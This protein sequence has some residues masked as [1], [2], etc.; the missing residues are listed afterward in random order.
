M[1]LPT[2]LC[3]CRQCRA[4]I[5]F[6]SYDVNAALAGIDEPEETSVWH[7]CGNGG[8]QIQCI[9]VYDSPSFVTFI[10]YQKSSLRGWLIAVTHPVEMII[11]YKG[12]Q[13]NWK[14]ERCLKRPAGTTGCSEAG[15]GEAWQTPIHMSCISTDETTLPGY[16]YLGTST[17]V[18]WSC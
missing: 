17:W 12:Q 7:L 4:F 9:I 11:F 8:R 6:S 10:L 14:V 13:N 5:R 1:I 15:S 2:L 3:M 18:L 16:Q